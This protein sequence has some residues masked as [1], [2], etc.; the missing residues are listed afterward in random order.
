MQ[1]SENLWDYYRTIVKDEVFPCLILDLDLFLENA[2]NIAK[3]LEKTTTNKKTIRVAS[4]SVR[5]VKMLEKIFSTNNIY[6]GILSYSLREAL[7]LSE[8]GFKDILVAYPE[9]NKNDLTRLCQELA[10]SQVDITLMVDCVEQVQ[11]IQN[12]ASQFNVVVKICMDIDLSTKYGSLHF[13]VRRSPINNFSTSLQFAKE[14]KQ[15]KNVQLIG[16]MGYEAQI[17][18]VPDRS[19]AKNF[20]I[21]FLIRFLKKRSIKTIKARREQIVK[22]LRVEGFELPLI[23]GGG[24]GSVESTGNEEIVTEVTVGSGFYSPVLFDYYNAFHH[25]P[26]LFYS[27]EVTRIPIKDIYTCHGGGFVASGSLGI[28]KIPKPFLPVGS[29]L[30]EN[31]MAGE[32]QTPIQNK[33]ISLEIG[34][35]VFMRH[36]K[37]GELCEHF[38]EI[39]VISKGSI[40]DRY[41]TYRGEGFVFL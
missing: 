12:I 11:I 1:A 27:L 36:A 35:P 15:F 10:K 23:N 26:A 38:T 24:T 7:F 29:T 31:E 41:K 18:G 22:A 40:I 6:Q 5:S 28:D 33:R 9:I 16:I 37:A 19:P 13:G 4:K 30:L 32:V 20:L 34:D 39:I 17:A 3:R 2:S 14:I 8:R 25:K 21:N